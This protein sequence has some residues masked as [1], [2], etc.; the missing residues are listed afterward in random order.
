MISDVVIMYL[1]VQPFTTLCMHIANSP[2]LPIIVSVVTR[3]LRSRG[4]FILFC[5]KSSKYHTDEQ[6]GR[7]VA[8]RFPLRPIARKLV[9]FRNESLQFFV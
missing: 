9:R 3:A 2:L 4:L 5:A 6:F 7:S 1:M 8:K